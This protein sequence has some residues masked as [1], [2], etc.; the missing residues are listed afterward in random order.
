MRPLN[1]FD[2]FPAAPTTVRAGSGPYPPR[3]ES[4]QTRLGEVGHRL[5]VL[6]SSVRSCN[7]S[8]E[9]TRTR[10]LGIA[11]G[12]ETV[13]CATARGEGEIEALHGII[14]MLEN[15]VGHSASYASQ[16]GTL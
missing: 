4:V 3:P 11:D 5:Q 15:A 2:P 7:D 10:L 16:L 9:A 14:D 12:V 1:E 6:L 13:G 8:L